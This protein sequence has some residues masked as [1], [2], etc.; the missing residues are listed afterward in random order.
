MKLYLRIFLAFILPLAVGCLF[1]LPTITSANGYVAG[2]AFIPFLF[3][4]VIVCVVML[5]VGLVMAG[6]KG[7]PGLWWLPAG[8]MVLI[9]FMGLAMFAKQFEI[10]AYREEPM[11]PLTPEVSNIVLFK[12]GTTEE[13]I[14]RFWNETLATARPDGRGYEHIAGVQGIGRMS[15][16]DGHEVV[17]FSFFASATDEQK[18]YV[19]NR[20]RSSPTVLELR[21]N[22]P[23]KDYMPSSFPESSVGDDRPRK[24]VVTNR[25]ST[26][27]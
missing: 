16:R 26:P 20:V 25:A 12:R 3:L 11:V 10:G 5:I 8:P 13:E 1:I 7:R 18:G 2:F 22:V 15:A 14:S 4:S 19:Y 9:G 23:T 6:V 21:E 17:T 24:V 27:P